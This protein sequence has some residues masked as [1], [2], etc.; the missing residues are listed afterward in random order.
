[1]LTLKVLD[2]CCIHNVSRCMYQQNSWCSY[3]EAMCYTSKC[4]STKTLGI[5][6]SYSRGIFRT[7]SMKHYLEGYLS[8]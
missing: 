7:H 1:M 8:V 2:N 4:D 6:V 5:D 3:F